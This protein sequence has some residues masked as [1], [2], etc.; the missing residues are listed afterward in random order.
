[1]T[2][3]T[4]ADIPGWPTEGLSRYLTELWDR[5]IRVT[6]WTMA[7]TGA[8]RWNILFDAEDGDT[9]HRLAATIVPNAEIL[10]QPFEYEPRIITL[11]EQYGVPV[12]H[13]HGVCLDA[14]YAGGPFF[15][16]D[17]V[18]GETVPR[19]VMRI[20]ERN[21]LG[22]TVVRQCARAFA[23]LHKVPVA[24]APPGLTG[25]DGPVFERALER[26]N[27]TRSLMLVPSPTFA[28][29]AAWLRRHKP[30][31]IQPVLVHGDLRVGNIIVSE[32]G[33][34]AVLDWEGARLGDPM[35]DLAWMCLRMWRFGND[36]LEVA[37]LAPREV[38]AEAYTE[39][40]GEWDEDRFDWWKVN[41]ELRWGVGLALQSAQHLDG[42]L[43]S[44]VLAGSGRRVAEQEWNV[45]NLLRPSYG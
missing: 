30:P 20:I 23:A 14:S 38:L 44:I 19:Q 39:A 7:S 10:I 12:A 35:E 33:L 24:D 40:G 25:S 29:G 22:E 17:R 1:V 45:L 8:R 4:G 3:T 42:T 36:E 2:S 15:V 31:D 11:A 43:Q 13:I 9:T 32:Q 26:A 5:E 6:K 34:A 37:G 16:G 28:L 21:D 27:E 41:G 18:D